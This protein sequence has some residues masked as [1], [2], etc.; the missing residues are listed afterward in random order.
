MPLFKEMLVE[1]GIEKVAE[2]LLALE[3]HPSSDIQ[4]DF[5]FLSAVFD[6]KSK[7]LL[8]LCKKEL[9]ALKR[10]KKQFRHD[11][12]ISAFASRLSIFCYNVIYRLALKDSVKAFELLNDFLNLEE[13]ATMRS[14]YCG[15]VQNVFCQGWDALAELAKQVMPPQSSEENSW[16]DFIKEKLLEIGHKE[17]HKNIVIGFK[18]L[19][20]KAEIYKI[21]QEL[22][23]IIE[24]KKHSRE[25]R[26]AAHALQSIADAYKD[27]DLYVKACIAYNDGSDL[28][29][30]ECF[31]IADRLIQAWR[32]DEALEWLQKAQHAKSE[33][34]WHYDEEK[35]YKLTVQALELNGDYQ[36]S[37]NVKREWCHRSLD[38]ET[39]NEIMASLPS[40][41]EK[42]TFHDNMIQRAKCVIPKGLYFLFK[43]Q[44]FEELGRFV[45]KNEQLLKNQDPDLLKQISIVLET[46]DP[47]GSTLFCRLFINFYLSLCDFRNEVAER[48]ARCERLSQNI[49]NWESF[50]NHEAYMKQL[51]S[52]YRYEWDFWET[53]NNF[54]NFKS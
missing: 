39:Y 9:S 43:I 42:Q 11:E 38:R 51:K 6:P 17:S 13:S 54:L 40:E 26:Y 10:G 41:Q 2:V 35:F 24:S 44:E 36:K 20:E 25:F 46:I 30:N 48:L 29:R 22:F 37:L 23:Y 47:L 18:S 8:S 21:V 49:K 28:H 52:K 19:L 45:R 32:A 1:A 33:Y 53:Y 14:N 50:K 34:P 27:V 31:E 7:A 4:K 12:E 16:K 3:H 15:Q 5:Q